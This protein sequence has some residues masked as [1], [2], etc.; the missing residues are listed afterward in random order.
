KLGFAPP[1]RDGGFVDLESAPEAFVASGSTGCSVYLDPRRD[2]VVV[3][4]S[5]AGFSGH[6]SKKFAGL[7]ADIHAALI[8][9]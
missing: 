5:N 1:S 7:R 9:V 8:D 6:Q 2:M 3:F 4:L